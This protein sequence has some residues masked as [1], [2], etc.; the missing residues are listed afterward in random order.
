MLRGDIDSWAEEALAKLVTYNVHVFHGVIVQ[1]LRRAERMWRARTLLKSFT[2]FVAGCDRSKHTLNLNQYAAQHRSRTLLLSTIRVWWRGAL[3]RRDA[4]D[5][6][7]GFTTFWAR[8][9]LRL[10]MVHWQNHC[11]QVRSEVLIRKKAIRFLYFSFLRRAWRGW[12]YHTASAHEK[13]MTAELFV[14]LRVAREC[15]QNWHGLIVRKKQRARQL[16]MGGYSPTVIN[17]LSFLITP[18]SNSEP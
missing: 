16:E 6:F 8:Y 18:T 17:L 15:L 1:A 14:F 12:I 11:V 3:L 10:V 7:H 13:K 2:A 4:K 9:R 5:K